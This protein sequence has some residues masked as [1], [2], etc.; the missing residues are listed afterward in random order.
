MDEI[1]RRILVIDDMAEIQADFRRVLSSPV[2]SSAAD[3]LAADIL[4][5]EAENEVAMPVYEV[6]CASQG[7]QGVE[8]V[9]KAGEEGRPYAVAFVDVRMPPG[10]DGVETIKHIW[11]VD[12]DIQVII[13]TAYSDYSW[14]RIQK[15]LGATDQLLVL[16]KPFESVEIQQIA[17]ALVQKWNLMR[18]VK[19]QRQ[20]LQ[21]KNSTLRAER[22]FSAGLLETA[23]TIMLLLNRDGSIEYINPFM[24]QL[25]GYTL[26][27]VKGKDWFDTFL[28]P[29]DHSE[30][31][32]LFSAAISDIKTRGNINPIIAK[33]GHEIIVEWYDHTHRNTQGE[34]IGLLSIGYDVTERKRAEAEL[35]QTKE[36]FRQVV[37]QASDGIFIADINGQYVDVNSAGC[38][39]L[40][41][42]RDEII[43]KTI[44]DL[45][46]PEDLQRLQKSKDEMLDGGTNTSEWRLKR[47]DGTY[48]PVEVSANIL[49]DG[50]WQGFVRDI[51]ERKQAEAQVRRLSQ[52]IEQ[53]GEA[54]AITDLEGTIEY[55]NPAFT[56]LTG[57]SEEEAIGKNHRLLKGGG[58][59]NQA[60]RSM[61]ETISAGRMW[62]GKVINR[63]KSGELYPAMLTISPIRD[64]D[65]NITNYIGIQQGLKEYEALEEQFHQAQKM[66][67]IGTLVGGIAHD[68]NNTLA[69]I[70]GNLYLAKRKVA[71]MPEVIKHL[72][73][74]EKLSFSA[75]ATI[76]KLLAFSRKD[77]VQMQTLSISSFLKEAIKLQRVSLPE[78]IAFNLDIKEKD[79]LV[80]GDINQLQ[81]VLMNLVNNAFDAVAEAASPSIEVVLERFHADDYFMQHHNV[82]DGKDFAL[83]RVRDNGMGI[84]EEHLDH[85]FEP[86]FTTKSVDKGSGLGLSMV[87]GTIC[88]HGGVIDVESKPGS[89][90]VFSLYLPLVSAEEAIHL[91]AE[92]DEVVMGEGETILLVDDNESVL[93]IGRDILEGL[94]YH[95]ITALDGQLAVAE[96]R[97]HFQE[98][99]L[100]IL[101]VVMPHLGGPE[102]LRQMRMINP[103]A[104]A[105]YATGYDK[106]SA[107]GKEREK[108]DERVISKPYAVCEI[109]QVIR[110]VLEG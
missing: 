15:E 79:M 32:E 44:V 71:A 13:V 54:V 88:S 53:S 84:S 34:V 90:A 74:V 35:L 83:I 59:H 22:D 57:Y 93:E 47:K 43:G 64:E 18:R 6:D 17:A 3:S 72:D 58:Q 49:P 65:G 42:E 87:Y 33:D 5:H 80:R 103:D 14:E 1:N 94:N 70:T 67:A 30:I 45:F 11:Q 27:E 69:G 24:E 60:Y 81:Q 75:A 78:N 16:K 39:M 10:W 55:I 31:R 97:R 95:V 105:I 21:D 73:V 28:P 52:A 50:Q 96:Y 85:I 86:F 40:G 102:A 92:T 68:F 89:G 8:L 100:V 110:Q 63:A 2:A 104:K 38:Q 99:D 12:P 108:I 101:D 109:S 26:E 9:Q 23:Q 25:S 41:F 66:E 76:R 91:Q 51:S 46:P 36:R 98:I 19:E 107:L 48:V 61:W 37:E 106:L 77:V 56:T 7:S 29:A 82:V 20:E 4:G 62:Q